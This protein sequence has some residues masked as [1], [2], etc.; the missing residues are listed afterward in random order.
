MNFVAAQLLVK[1]RLRGVEKMK[2]GHKFTA[3]IQRKEELPNSLLNKCPEVLERKS[4]PEDYH[5]RA[6]LSN[7][8]FV[9]VQQR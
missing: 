9:S 8:S 3:K 4:D 1:S 5:R 6:V 7:T 2:A